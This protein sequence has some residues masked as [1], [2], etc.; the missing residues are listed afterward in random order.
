MPTE[1]M[2]SRA[3]PQPPAIDARI[4]A[5]IIA[6]FL[7]FVAASMT[8]LFYYLD[9]YAPDIMTQAP[10]RQVPQPALQR[11]PSSDLAAFEK[12]QRAEL[13][14]YAWIDRDRNLARI[15]IEDAMRIVA[16]RGDHGF[17]PVAPPDAAPSV[18]PGAQP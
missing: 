17:D 18:T 1:E 7:A 4:V 2:G 3:L 9:V 12:A 15:P 11:S 10:P 8:G 14:T 16:S 6:G 13:T 5:W